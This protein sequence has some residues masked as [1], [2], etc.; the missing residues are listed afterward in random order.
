MW[1]IVEIFLL[2]K[3]WKHNLTTLISR[4]NHVKNCGNYFVEKIVKTQLDNFDFTR[5]FT[6]KLLIRHF[7]WFPN[8]VMILGGK[9]T[10]FENCPKMGLF[11]HFSNIVHEYFFFSKKNGNHRFCDWRINWERVKWKVEEECKEAQM[12]TKNKESLGWEPNHEDNN[13]END[14]KRCNDVTHFF[15]LHH[16]GKT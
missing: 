11:R 16:W 1:K 6:M 8:T 9:N 13:D 14:Q 4:K 2:K 3:S 7:G 10:L 5:K 12:Q 15:S